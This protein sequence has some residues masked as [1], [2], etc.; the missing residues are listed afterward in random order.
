MESEFFEEVAIFFE[1]EGHSRVE[2]E[3]CGEHEQLRIGGQECVGDAFESFEIDAFVGGVLVDDD[4][5]AAVGAD[6]IGQIVLAD[7]VEV[8]EVGE[9]L[10]WRGGG[11]RRP[12]SCRT[13][14]R[15]VMC[16]WGA[17]GVGVDRACEIVRVRRR[18]SMAQW[19]AQA[20]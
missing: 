8:G 6:E 14:L 13:M 18:C 17:F 5:I 16:L 15:P 20:R 7:V 19:W 4:E 11:R 10:A 1:N 9:W 3:Q 12:M 2:V